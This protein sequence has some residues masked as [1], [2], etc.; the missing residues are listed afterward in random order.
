MNDSGR[1]I[2]TRSSSRKFRNIKNNC[3]RQIGR[4]GTPRLNHKAELEAQ[5][6]KG[7]EQNHQKSK[8]VTGKRKTKMTIRSH[9]NPQRLDEEGLLVST[10]QINESTVGPF[11]LSGPHQCGPDAEMKVKL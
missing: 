3:T 1:K 7:R 8:R 9:S 2:N 10:P 5:P 6:Q 4:H 11:R